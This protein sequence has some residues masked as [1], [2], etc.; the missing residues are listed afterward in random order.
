MLAFW[1]LGRQKL[2]WG[3][4]LVEMLD[5]RACLLQS[6][7]LIRD[8]LGSSKDERDYTSKS[9]KVSD[10]GS[11]LVLVTELNLCRPQENTRK[12]TLMGR[13]IFLETLNVWCCNRNIIRHCGRRASP[14][15]YKGWLVAELS[16]LDKYIE[17][18]LLLIVNIEQWIWELNLE[19]HYVF[20]AKITR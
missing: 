18:V 14:R 9:C 10:D 2:I 12:L 4:I 1:F 11:R 8:H 5:K 20:D 16:S 15:Q 6:K 7:H 3:L 17:V 13:L 19:I